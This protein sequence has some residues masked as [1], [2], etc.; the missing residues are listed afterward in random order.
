MALEMDI[1][2]RRR[3][4]RSSRRA[5]YRQ[6]MMYICGHLVSH[7]FGIIIHLQL[8][9]T[10]RKRRLKFIF[11]FLL[12]THTHTQI[13]SRCWWCRVSHLFFVCYQTPV[14]LWDSIVRS[15]V[16]FGGSTHS[17]TSSV[18]Q[19]AYWVFGLGIDRYIGR[20]IL[21]ADIRVFYVYRIGR[22]AA[23]FRRFFIFFFTCSTSP[24]F[25]I[26]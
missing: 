18:L 26:C 3:R 24:V 10:P 14:A 9:V 19:N 23:D 25:T 15:V 17:E 6:V 8:F 1:A 11:P 12:N 2:A 21:S 7:F 4:R 20:P 13:K 5:T 16:Y 22:Y